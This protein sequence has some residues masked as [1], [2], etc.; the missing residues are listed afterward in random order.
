VFLQHAITAFGNIALLRHA[1]DSVLASNAG[2]SKEC[3]PEAAN[4]LAALVIV[5]ALD[6]CTKLE[7]NEHLESLESLKDIALALQ[8][9]DPSIAQPVVNECHPV[10]IA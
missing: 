1:L 4:V 3:I 10:A 5:Q 6:E 7:L 8:E 2:L 9:V